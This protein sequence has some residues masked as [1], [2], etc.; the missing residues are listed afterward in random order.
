M[1]GSR[2]WSGARLA[3]LVREQ[4]DGG[5][6]VAVEGLGRFRRNGRAFELIPEARPKVFIAYVAEDRAAATRLYDDLEARGFDPWLDA[7]KLLAGQNW[8]RAIERAIDVSDFVVLCLSRRGVS[9][10][11][12]FEAELRYALECARRVPAGEIFLL[13]ARLDACRPPDR[14]ARE[15]QYVDLFPDWDRGVTRLASAM[16]AATSAR[17]ASS[18]RRRR[19]GPRAR[20]Q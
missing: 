6:E 10:R 8:P 18:S 14:L 20:P 2:R 11:G 7:R 3:A 15:V 19:A 13:P 9:K 17:R 16:R 5:A 1:T 12:T 4:L